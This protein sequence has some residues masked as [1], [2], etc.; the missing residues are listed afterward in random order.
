MIIKKA[1]KNNLTEILKIYKEAREY[2]ALNGN[3][4]QWGTNY[5]PRELIE[6]DITEGKSYI[7]FD[8]ENKICGVF[9]FAIENDPMYNIIEEGQWLNN[10]P[11]AVVHRIAVSMNTHNKGIASKCIDYAVRLCKESNIFDLRMD[12]HRDNVPMQHFLVK[13][14]FEKCGVVFVDDGTERLAYHKVI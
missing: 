7:A 9:Y 1:D 3:K 12:T 14:G 13:K 10:N 6:K 2:M 11:Y 8:E 4:D 5:P